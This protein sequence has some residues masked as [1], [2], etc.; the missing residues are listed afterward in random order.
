MLG[1]MYAKPTPPREVERIW[2]CLDYA[3]CLQPDLNGLEKVRYILGELSAKAEAYQELRRMRVPT[4]MA[5]SDNDALSKVTQKFSENV[6]RS[7]SAS[8]DLDDADAKKGKVRLNWTGL[9]P[10]VPHPKYDEPEIVDAQ[11]VDSPE[12]AEMDT[13]NNPGSG[14][15][16]SGAANV[17]FNMAIFSGASNVSP[18]PLNSVSPMQS[19]TGSQLNSGSIDPRGGSQ[20]MSP[21]ADLMLDIDWVSYHPQCPLVLVVLCHFF[22]LTNDFSTS[23]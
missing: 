18:P 6:T 9:G 16:A 17:G 14:A 7:R 22:L 8:V 11:S 12:F 13:G 4:A 20:S 23:E 15:G 3:F 2:K 21:G 19:D 1:E 10:A 5:N